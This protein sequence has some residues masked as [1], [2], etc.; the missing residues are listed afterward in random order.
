[1]SYSSLEKLPPISTLRYVHM[2]GAPR[3]CEAREGRP[4]GA[5]HPRV[6][7]SQRIN[8]DSAGGFTGRDMQAADCGGSLVA[9]GRGKEER[10]ECR[11]NHTC[12]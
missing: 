5:R 4:A 2:G 7:V 8:S 10:R 12:H 11:V 6:N 1:M 3:W 9:A